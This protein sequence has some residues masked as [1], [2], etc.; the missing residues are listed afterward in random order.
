MDLQ[1]VVCEVMD[2]IEMAQDRDRWR[3]HVTAVMNYLIPY[4]V[5]NFLTSR[6]PA[7]FSRRTLLH[8][9]NYRVNYIRHYTD[10]HKACIRFVM[11]VRPSVRTHGITRPPWDGIKLIIEIFSENVQKRHVLLNSDMQNRY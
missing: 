10:F 3:E 11:G 7:S 6:K 9:V 2:W 5:G 4:I 1:E 8:G